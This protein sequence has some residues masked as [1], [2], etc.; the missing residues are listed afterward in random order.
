MSNQTFVILKP[1]CVQRWLTGEITSRFEKKWCK[2]VAS[3]MTVLSEDILK[4]HYAHIADKPFFPGV[5]K[6]MTSSPVIMQIR[7]WQWV[8]EMIRTMIWV[9]NPAEAAPGTIR[10]DYAMSIWANIIHASEDAQ[11][12]WDEI[13]RFFGDEWTHSYKRCDEEMLYE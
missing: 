8:V 12:A 9:T 4:E 3:K 10:A 13:K 6:Y 5:V 11:Q 1:D 7:Q 2:L